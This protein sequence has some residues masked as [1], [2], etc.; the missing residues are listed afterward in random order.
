[1]SL[2]YL[3]IGTL[4]KIIHKKLSTTITY[5]KYV[6]LSK[7]FTILH[8]FKSFLNDHFKIKWSFKIMIFWMKPLLN[9]FLNEWNLLNNLLNPFLNLRSH[10][11]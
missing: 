1:M 11:I 2:K 7:V 5:K 9:P 8:I 3:I 10:L 6:I 4:A